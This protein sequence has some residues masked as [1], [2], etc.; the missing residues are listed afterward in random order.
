MM[1]KQFLKLDSAG[2]AS[3]LMQCKTGYGVKNVHAVSQQFH[4]HFEKL[5]AFRNM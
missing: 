4:W 5:S 2:L 3:P 1:H